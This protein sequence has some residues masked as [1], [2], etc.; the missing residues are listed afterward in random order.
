MPR[1]LLIALLFSATTLRADGLVIDSMDDLHFR[2]P[3]EKGKAEQVEG[4]SGK[5]VRFSFD[6]DCQGAFFTSPIR[7]RPEWDEAA[8]FSFWV[9]GDGSDHFG[10]LELIYDE[11][12][13]IR[14]D[15]MF[16]IKSTEWTKITVAWRDLIPVLPGPRA[17]LLN[18]AKGNKPSKISALWV[19]KWW[20]WRDYA[21]HS[22]AIDDIRLEKEITLDTNDYKPSG[23]PLRRVLEKLKAG[24]PVTIVTMADSLADYRHWSNR[25]ISWPVLLQKRLE[26]KYHTKVTIHNPALGGTQLRHNLVL[27]PRWVAEVPEPDLV[28]ICFGGNDWDGG[29]RGPEFEESNR[30]AIDRLRRATKGKADVLLL[31]T[32]PSVARWTTM[33]ELAEGCR[34]AAKDRNAGLADAEKAF[35]DAGKDK[36]EVLYVWDKTH[37]SRAGHEVIARTIL[38]AIEQA[39]VAEK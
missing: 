7:G 10:G 23:P 17:K 12:Y 13:A 36:K 11:D 20:Y 22:Y 1:S 14:Y 30:D 35:L 16:P 19:G 25:E 2:N 21:A 28:T 33:Q 26:E 31:T 15:F 18:P 3:K 32:V 38:E 6:K 29:M 8:G 39:G 9:K 37:L 24:K 34:K 27:I 4:H 5:A